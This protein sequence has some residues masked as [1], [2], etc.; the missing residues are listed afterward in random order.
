M[1]MEVAYKPKLLRIMFG[2]A[3]RFKNFLN[4]AI[5]PYHIIKIIFILNG[6]AMLQ[7]TCSAASS[8]EAAGESRSFLPT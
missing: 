1:N 6:A 4:I 3:N 2:P 5:V 7:V 8:V